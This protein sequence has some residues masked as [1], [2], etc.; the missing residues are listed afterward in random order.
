MRGEETENTIVT[1][2]HELRSVCI[3]MSVGEAAALRLQEFGWDY[4]LTRRIALSLSLYIYPHSYCTATFLLL[5]STSIVFCHAFQG[6]KG[7]KT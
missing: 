3:E 6:T 2:E 5:R 1:L 7:K 4:S